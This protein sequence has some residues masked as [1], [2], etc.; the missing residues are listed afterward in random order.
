MELGPPR[1]PDSIPA[2]GLLADGA[3][4]ARSPEVPDL[5]PAGNSAAP[6][7]PP[8]C[9]ATFLS[10]HSGAA[11]RLTQRSSLHTPR[12]TKML[13]PV[14]DCHAGPAQRNRRQDRTGRAQTQPELGTEGRSGLKPLATTSPTIPIPTQ[15]GPTAVTWSLLGASVGAAK[16]GHSS[17]QLTLFPPAHLTAQEPEVMGQ[18]A[19][20]LRKR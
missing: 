10:C 3:G 4:G 19:N 15:L 8:P 5:P 16:Q 20:E 13:I 18:G 6:A 1:L 17:L 12:E 14:G 9:L 11:L 7:Q 2:A